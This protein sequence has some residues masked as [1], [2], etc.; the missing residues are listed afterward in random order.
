MIPGRGPS[1]SG[2][3]RGKEARQQTCRA[4]EMFKRKVLQFLTLVSQGTLQQ[5]F[6][7]LKSRQTVEAFVEECRPRM[8][9][10]YYLN[11]NSKYNR[12]IHST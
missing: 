1:G 8:S 2:I 7:F 12:F 11:M 3:S 10:D 4:L 6:Y 9:P 5:S